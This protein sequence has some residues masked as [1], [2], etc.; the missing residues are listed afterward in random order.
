MIDYTGEPWTVC[1]RCHAR[2]TEQEPLCRCADVLMPEIHTLQKENIRL[3]EEAKVV[4]QA[5]AALLGEDN[6]EWTLAYMA[7][8]AEAMS[9]KSHHEDKK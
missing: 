1:M 4:R 7:G 6:P 5:F 3:T 2:V 8:L 9:K